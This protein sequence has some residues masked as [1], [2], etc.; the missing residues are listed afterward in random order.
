MVADD[1]GLAPFN[2]SS[3]LNTERAFLDQLFELGRG[4][5]QRWL[6]HHRADIGV[7]ATLDIE[8]DFLV[9]SSGA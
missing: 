6:K 4:A 8:R 7:R 1:A 2:A 9:K 3:K 5:A